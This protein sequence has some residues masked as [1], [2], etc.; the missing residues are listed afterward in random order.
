MHYLTKMCSTANILIDED[1]GIYNHGG[2]YA[3][4]QYKI[5]SIFHFINEKARTVNLL[6]N[7]WFLRGEVKESCMSQAPCIFKI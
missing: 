5:S 4:E 6:F 2:P 1:T 7:F 3:A